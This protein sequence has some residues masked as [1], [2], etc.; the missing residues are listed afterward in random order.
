[1][2]QINL[3]INL[4]PCLSW[5]VSLGDGFPSSHSPQ[6]AVHAPA[7]SSIFPR[8][9]WVHLAW[10]RWCPGNPCIE[11]NQT[12]G[13]EH[14]VL[15]GC[16]LVSLVFNW[17]IS[18]LVSFVCQVNLLHFIVVGLF[19]FCLWMCVC[20]RVSL[21]VFLYCSYYLPVFVI[22]TCLGYGFCF[23]F[24]VFA[25]IP[26]N[27]ITSHLWTLHSSARDQFL[28]PW[29]GSANSKTKDHQRTPNPKEY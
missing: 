27:A 13:G 25:S 26:F 11:Y 29:S 9:I 21:C 14:K 2:C 6:D 1:M 24:L 20:V 8:L 22:A 17:G 16:I 28:S 12:F 23:L 19:L 5:H 3:I 18:F 4:I 10:P 7:S 15:S